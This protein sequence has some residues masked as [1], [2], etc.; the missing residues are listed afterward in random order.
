MTRSKIVFI[1]SILVAL[2]TGY[3]AGADEIDDMF[4]TGDEFEIERFSDSNILLAISRDAR[5]ACRK[6]QCTLHSVT[7]N[8]QR[9]SVT[10]NIG[11][12]NVPGTW[13]NGTNINIGDDNPDVPRD[14]WGI[15]VRYEIGTCTQ[16]IK[17]P[18]ALFYSLNRYLYGL[19]NADGT[20]RRG[21]TPAD[22]AM[23]VFY[24]TIMKQASGCGGNNSSTVN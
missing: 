19:M 12:G 10:F 2:L 1:A 6:G 5:V 8:H 9:F 22:E 11:E 20:P 4:G 21:F 23:I 15:S 7:Q 14:F 16:K 13:G 24:S 18:R 3:Q 17:V